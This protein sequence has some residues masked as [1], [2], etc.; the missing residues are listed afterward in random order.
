MINELKEWTIRAVLKDSHLVEE[1]EDYIKIGSK[2]YTPQ[3]NPDIT[4]DESKVEYMRL[5]WRL[6]DARVW[7]N[8]NDR[9][10]TATFRNVTV[11]GAV[12][13]SDITTSKYYFHA[14][15]GTAL[16]KAD[17]PHYLLGNG[18]YWNNASIR[19]TQDAL[20]VSIPK[21]VW[22]VYEHSPIVVF[23]PYAQHRKTEVA[24]FAIVVDMSSKFPEILIVKHEAD[25]LTSLNNNTGCFS[26]NKA[27]ADTYGFAVPWYAYDKVGRMCIKGMLDMWNSMQ[28]MKNPGSD[29]WYRCQGSYKH[30]A[31]P[32]NHKEGYR[33]ISAPRGELKRVADRVHYN[34]SEYLET[35]AYTLGMLDNTLSY[36][37]GMDYVKYLSERDLSVDTVGRYCLQVDLKDFF[38]N[39]G[40]QTVSFLNRLDDDDGSFTSVVTDI[41]MNMSEL[42][43]FTKVFA[44]G[45]KVRRNNDPTRVITELFS[46]CMTTLPLWKRDLG[47]Y[48]LETGEKEPWGCAKALNR[49]RNKLYKQSDFGKICDL[50]REVSPY[51]PMVQ[52]GVPQGASFSGDIANIIAGYLAKNMKT[53]LTEMLQD[54]GYKHEP[55]VIVYSD[56]IYMFYD[57]PF[58]MLNIIR[59][60]FCELYYGIRRLIVPWKILNFDRTISDVK[61]LGL[62]IDKDGEIRLSRQYRRRINQAIIHN[63]KNNEKWGD[64]EEGRKNWYE[65]VSQYTSDKYSRKLLGFGKGLTKKKKE[66][67]K[68]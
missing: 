45:F 2:T 30:W 43:G 20:I 26:L 50:H 46:M 40:P 8:I 44:K 55:T 33:L 28:W 58:N 54:F 13:P 56:N 3:V 7:T 31:I 18:G 51:T 29:K 41:F 4:C 65:H 12:P 37:S 36:R 24:D 21:S 60:E 52:K 27:L 17:E 61:M 67:S 62:I 63:W 14:S 53:N 66:K 15:N 68:E 9:E 49:Y 16:N 1:D 57:A 11:F 22:A 32:K 48:N 35:H 25:I 34:L 42:I 6:K 19:F 64:V 5:L 59:R 10:L 39:I 38:T 47:G 23:L